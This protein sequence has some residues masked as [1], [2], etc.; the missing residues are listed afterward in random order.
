MKLPTDLKLLSVI[1]EM[2]YDKFVNFVKSDP[3]RSAK[4]Y[5]PIDCTAVAGRLGVDPDI[6]FGRLY[7]HLEKKYG[8]T[9]DDGAKV[10]FFSLKVGEDVKCVNFPLLAS[11]LA[12]LRHENRKFWIGIWIAVLALVVSAG[13][14]SISLYKESPNHQIQPTAERDG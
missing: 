7:Y 1:Y 10:H 9:Q 12:G 14:L 11:V 5:V 13:S 8:Y 6:V 2:Y 3:S 4:I